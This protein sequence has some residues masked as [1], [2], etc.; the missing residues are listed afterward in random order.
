MWVKLAIIII[1]SPNSV[2]RNEGREAVMRKTCVRWNIV[3]REK[4]LHVCVCPVSRSNRGASTVL[5][6]SATASGWGSGGSA[7]GL[8]AAAAGGSVSTT[9]ALTIK[10]AQPPHPPHLK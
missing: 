10:T 9:G 1:K 6:L 3:S 8:S 4:R 5:P 7:A 2:N